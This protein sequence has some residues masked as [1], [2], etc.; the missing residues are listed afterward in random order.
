MKIESLGYVGVGTPRASEFERFGPDILGTPL[1]TEPKDGVVRLRMDD[2]AYRLAIHS[3]ERDRLLYIGWEVASA[4]ELE[5]AA[6]HLRAQGIT[7]EDADEKTRQMRHVDGFVRFADPWG[8]SHEIFH[9]QRTLGSFTPAR[10]ITGFV[11]GEMG[12]GHIVLLLPDREEAVRFFRD[13]MGFRVSDYIDDPLPVAFF[14]CNPRH[15]SLAVGQV[16]PIRGLHHVMFE[17][18]DL[19]DVGRTYDLCKEKNVPYSMELGRHSNDFMTSF[20][21]RTP[22]GFEIEYGWGGRLVDEETWKVLHLA[23][24]SNWG[25]KNTGLG[26]PRTVEPIA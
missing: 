6:S 24:G 1:W 12:L 25:H 18:K 9:G 22:G 11:T 19:D 8:L 20:Y 26:P 10:D 16:G 5:A 3:D 4:R 15:H 13:V 21:V 2:R 7:V 23:K 14:H 17:L